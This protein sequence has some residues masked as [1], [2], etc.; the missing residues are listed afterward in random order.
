MLFLWCFALLILAVPAQNAYS[1]FN[2]YHSPAEA[3]AM[4]QKIASGGNAAMHKLAQTPGGNNYYVLEIGKET[5]AAGKS[6][7]AIFVAANM[8]GN[9]P[10]STEAALYLA[11]ELAKKTEYQQNYTWYILA[12]G[13][14]DAAKTYFAALK[15]ENIRNLSPINDDMDEAID[16]D[17]FEDLDNDGY[18]TQMR[19]KSPNGKFIIDPLS[20]YFMR[21]ADASNGETG[22][23]EIYT[24]G[25]DND[26]DGEYNED[27]AGGVN[28]GASFPHLFK[29]HN[30]TSGLYPGKETETYS[31]I[32]FIMNHPEIAMTITF[33][34]SSFITIQPEGG[35]KGTADLNNIKIPHRF[36]G[37]INADPEKTYNFA[38][39]KEM[40]AKIMPPGMEVDESMII[41]MLGLGAAVN[42][43]KDDLKFY[44][45]INKEYADYLKNLKKEVKNLSPS[46]SKDASFELWSYYQLGIP[47]FSMNLWTLPEAK[48][49]K[50]EG[51]GI[52]LEKLENMSNDEF[53]QLGNEK[54]EAFLKENNAPAQFTAEKTVEMLKSGQFSTKQ[55]AGM[56]KKMAENAPKKEGELSKEQK[57][58][59]HY[60][61]NSSGGK[62]F[63][64]W[65]PFNHPQLGE[66]EIGG[67]VP[68]AQNTPQVN[69]IDSILSTNMPFIMDL[70]KKLAQLSIKSTEIKNLGKGVYQIDIYIENTGA[71]PFT[72]AMGKRNKQPAPAILSINGKNISFLQGLQRTPVLA[73]DAKS[74]QKFS[75]MIQSAQKQSLQIKIAAPQA[76]GNEKTINL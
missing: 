53:I 16:E 26:K 41:N 50:K 7:P 48:E 51:S 72:T 73:L 29:Y 49:E 4:M 43:E 75:F 40:V 47:T 37:Y 10:L 36:A 65:K 57:A 60:N 54:I 42:P 1:Q 58:F 5:K 30:P 39:V 66:V 24:E 56:M 59:I 15:F 27:P 13:N 68:F 25:I 23:F 34:T 28:I 2:Q 67:T 46:P 11:T 17:G 18:I 14:P 71:L 76:H 64:A 52:T 74:V 9:L 44:A 45:Q 33:G 35:R 70:S 31:L 32:E 19:K 62:A 6:L 20:H 21:K 3:E 63:V 55:M 61:E 69:L 12:N 38:E 8:E 22:I